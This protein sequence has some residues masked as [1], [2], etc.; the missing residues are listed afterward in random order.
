MRH[1][2]QL[3]SA[4]WRLYLACENLPGFDRITVIR[5]VDPVSGGYHSS[6][7]RHTGKKPLTAAVSIH[8]RPHGHA[9]LGGTSHRTR[10]YTQSASEG[11]VTACGEGVHRLLSIENYN[12]L[13]NLNASL[14]ADPQSPCADC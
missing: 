7:E 3:L 14:R 11:H 13:S 2:Q 5:C 10:R 8:S 12:E 9:G 1:G 4:G 6:L